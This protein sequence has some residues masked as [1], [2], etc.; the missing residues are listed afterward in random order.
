[1]RTLVIYLDFGV[2][3]WYGAIY[4]ERNTELRWHNNKGLMKVAVGMV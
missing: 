3:D 1:M 4:C 2:D